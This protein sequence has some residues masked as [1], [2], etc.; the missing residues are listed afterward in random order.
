MKQEV[1]VILGGSGPEMVFVEVEDHEGKG[2]HV[3]VEP[4]PDH[5]GLWR[6][7]P[8]VIGDD[9]A[10]DSSDVNHFQPTTSA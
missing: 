2:L 6:L 9:S 4:Y 1:F 8:F 10:T 7:G 3:P 5:A